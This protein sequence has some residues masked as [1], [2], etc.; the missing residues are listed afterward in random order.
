MESLKCGK[1]VEFDF[2]SGEFVLTQDASEIIYR[3]KG[4]ICSYSGADEWCNH[5]FCQLIDLY[6]GSSPYNYALGTCDHE[7]SIPV[8]WRENRDGVI[9]WLN[10][11]K[12][13]G[14]FDIACKTFDAIFD[15]IPV[16]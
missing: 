3:E 6:S 11:H 9:E 15:N 14:W 16:M 8:Y 2:N 13:D 4:C 7:K 12:G 10:K 1:Y 5:I